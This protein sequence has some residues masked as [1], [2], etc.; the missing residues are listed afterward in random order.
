MPPNQFP[1]K[2]LLL[3]MLNSG[4]V[5]CWVYDGSIGKTDPAV[6]IGKTNSV[7]FPISFSLPLLEGLR[8]GVF[9]I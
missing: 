3:L 4:K 5:I 2:E 1:K 9:S 6:S 8:Y 7:I